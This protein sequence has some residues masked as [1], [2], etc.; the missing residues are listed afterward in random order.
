[1][2][3]VSTPYN[4][5]MPVSSSDHCRGGM[6]ICG[7][8]YCGRCTTATSNMQLCFHRLTL[9]SMH[10][11]CSRVCHYCISSLIGLLLAHSGGRTAVVVS[12]NMHLVKIVRS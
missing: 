9:S 5:C 3:A 2:A 8:E 12:N 4:G 7:I 10:T 6:H 11:S 1:M